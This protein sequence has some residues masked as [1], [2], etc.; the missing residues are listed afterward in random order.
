MRP[1][2]PCF[3]PAALLTNITKAGTPTPAVQLEEKLF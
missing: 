1:M 2:N 3:L